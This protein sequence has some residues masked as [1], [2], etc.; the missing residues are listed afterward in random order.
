MGLFNVFKK[1][2]A[3]SEVDIHLLQQKM[4]QDIFSKIQKFLPQGWKKVDFHI[5]HTSRYYGIKFYVL[6]E[7]NEWIDCFKL[8][9]ENGFDF[10]FLSIDDNIAIV[11]N[12]LPKKHKWYVL[13]MIVDSQGKI[14]VAYDY[15][16]NSRDNE[17]ALFDYLLN[18][19]KEWDKKFKN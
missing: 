12:Q 1:K 5:Y 14:N 13:N 8:R 16:D 17:D 18:E 3:V 7:S 15:A 19:E 2:K 6:I 4:Y 11:W 9:D 10:N